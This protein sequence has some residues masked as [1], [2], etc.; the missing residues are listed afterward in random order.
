M[1]L[2][3]HK[4]K[5]HQTHT[6]NVHKKISNEKEFISHLFRVPCTA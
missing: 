1:A 4:N 5:N 2:P 3:C 6:K